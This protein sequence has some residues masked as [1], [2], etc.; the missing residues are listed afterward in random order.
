M[1]LQW[2]E[3]AWEEYTNLQ[4]SD[5]QKIKKINTLI[6]D[7]KRNGALIG[8][9]SPEP[10]KNNL[11]GYFSRQINEKDRLVYKIENECLTIVQCD[12]HY[13]DK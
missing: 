6:K 12:G 7:I 1:E 13:N 8:I 3:K 2:S 4:N 11:N 10:L 5:K 9:G